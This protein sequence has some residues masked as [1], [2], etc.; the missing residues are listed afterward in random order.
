MATF[1]IV[2]NP[3]N[4]A[5]AGQRID[6]ILD[7]VRA[8]NGSRGGVFGSNVR[9]MVNRSVFSGN[10]AAG[11]VAGTSFGAVEVNISGSVFSGNAVGVGNGGGAA[12]IRI[13]NSDI[14]F[15]DTALSGATQSYGNNRVDGNGALGTAP[16]TISLR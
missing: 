5:A 12:T 14:T 9:A 16:S 13:A 11:I 1:G 3:A 6:V 7:N 10:S 8:E 4:G 15:N 2:V